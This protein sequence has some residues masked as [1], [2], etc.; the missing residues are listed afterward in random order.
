MSSKCVKCPALKVVAIIIAIISLSLTIANAVLIGKDID[1]TTAK[2]G[3]N[4]QACVYVFSAVVLSLVTI[5]LIVAVF[6]QQDFGH[7]TGLNVFIYSLSELFWL[8]R[9]FSLVS[10]FVYRNNIQNTIM[11][12]KYRKKLANSMYLMDLQLQQERTALQFH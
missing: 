9:F 1:I 4:I 2:M 7:Y 10:S 6:L 5:K 3:R 8:M 11:H 12:G